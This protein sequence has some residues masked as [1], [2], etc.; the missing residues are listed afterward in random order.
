LDVFPLRDAR[1]FRLLDKLGK[2]DR[3]QYRRWHAK[4]GRLGE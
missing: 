4:F 1:R 3:R 2:I